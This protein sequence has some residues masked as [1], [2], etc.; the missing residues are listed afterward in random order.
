[1]YII[2]NKLYDVRKTILDLSN[3]RDYNTD[4]FSNFTN[5]EI[6]IMFKNTEKKINYKN[7]HLIL[8]VI[9]IH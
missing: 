8:C 6:E 3:L 1:M 9:I 4:K 5:D 2:L 7:M